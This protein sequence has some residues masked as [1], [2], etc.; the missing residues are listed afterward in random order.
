MPVIVLSDSNGPRDNYVVKQT[1]KAVLL[2]LM[3]DGDQVQYWFPK[4]QCALRKR[5]EI[6]IENGIPVETGK[7]IFEVSITEW[8]WKKKEPAKPMGCY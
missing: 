6:K 8:I 1:K 7:K 2:A 3:V 5:D 4:S